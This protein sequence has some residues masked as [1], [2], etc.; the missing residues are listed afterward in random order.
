[1]GRE[2]LGFALG[3]TV[4]MM[5]VLRQDAAMVEL[6]IDH[7]ADVNLAEFLEVEGD[8]FAGADSPSDYFFVT[9]AVLAHYWNT[10]ADKARKFPLVAPDDKKATP[11]SVALG[12]GNSEIVEL[13]R[14]RGAVETPG[15]TPASM[16]ALNCG[17]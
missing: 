7:G 13:L 15:A 3:A 14:A 16:P 1:M 8:D 4:L 2:R 12:T 11:L 10:T 17:S 6:L 9:D 5:A